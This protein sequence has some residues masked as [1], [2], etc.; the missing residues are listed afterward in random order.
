MPRPA[1]TRRVSRLAV[2]AVLTFAL[3]A[4]SK[5]RLELQPHDRLPAAGAHHEDETPVVT[6]ER[7]PQSVVQDT[8]GVSVDLAT[9]WAQQRV[10]VVFY[11]GHWCPHCQKQLADLEARRGEL[12]ATGTAIV[13]VSTDAPADA[14]ALHDRLR[15]GFAIYSDPEL[16]VIT[17]WGAQDYSQNIAKPSVFVVEPGGAISYRHIGATQTDR[18]TVDQLLAV[19]SAGGAAAAPE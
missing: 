19:L 16:A 2:A 11:M 7:A 5:P 6:N 17:R 9:V 4:C 14:A 8:T 12:A 10:L 3:V 13:A 1:Y 15:L 18:P